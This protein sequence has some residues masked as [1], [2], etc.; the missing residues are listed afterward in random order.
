MSGDHYFIALPVPEEAAAPLIKI[1]EDY[2]TDER[3]KTEV[4]PEDFHITLLF[5][6]GWDDE[7]RAALWEE[8]KSRLHEEAVFRL[9][10]REVGFF[11]RP[12]EPRVLFGGMTYSK[13]LMELQIKVKKLA[14]KHGFP[15]ESRPFTPHITV[16][17]GY[18]GD[19]PLKLHNLPSELP[20]VE[21]QAGEVILFKI[22]PG[23][24]PKYEK[25]DTITLHS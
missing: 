8:M 6:G 20:P 21:W 18:R 14:E 7:K 5:L 19:R 15:T 2:E 16:A 10:L 1:Q 11:G 4:H 23:K 13:A 24:F 9:K 12:A 3:F 22:H 25:I 17:K